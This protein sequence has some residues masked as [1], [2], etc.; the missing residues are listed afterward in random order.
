MIPQ[1]MTRVRGYR[2]RPLPAAALLAAALLAAGCARLGGP[3]RIG[4]F[5]P[6]DAVCG[7]RLDFG[8][9]VAPPVVVMRLS[10]PGTTVAD[11]PGHSVLPPVPPATGPQFPPGRPHNLGALVVIVSRDCARAPVVT[12]EPVNAARAVVIARGTNGGIAGLTITTSQVTITIRAYEGNRLVGQLA[13]P[14]GL[15]PCLPPVDSACPPGSRH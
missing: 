5:Y 15:S 4:D 8:G 6:R 3:G 7:T 11:A 9:G 12:V 10:A 13:L 14:E 2:P 1:S